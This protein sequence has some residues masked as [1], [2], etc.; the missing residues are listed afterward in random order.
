MGH[1]QGPNPLQVDN[2]T[3]LGF[4]N[5]NIKQ[6]MSKAIDMRLYWIQDRKDQG[7]FTIYLSPGTKKL[8]GYNR[9]HHPNSHHTV[10]Q[11]KI[12]HYL[13]YVSYLTQFLM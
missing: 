3:A 6:K 9:N 7:K 1:P 4:A 10:M 8:A 2:T 13:H 5:K 11:P 12:L